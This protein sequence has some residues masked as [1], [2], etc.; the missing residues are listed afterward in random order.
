MK[1]QISGILATGLILTAGV[2]FGAIKEGEFSISPVIGGYTF[3]NKQ[4]TDTSLM[5]GARAGYSLTESFGIEA[6]FDYVDAKS[7]QSLYRYGGELL[8]HFMP[9][10]R[11]VP[12][13][14][15]G[16]AGINLDF[17]DVN[18]RVHGAFDYGLGAKYFLTDS[19]ALRADVRH[20]IY[21]YND[22]TFNNVEYTL[23]AYIPFGGVKPAVKPLPVEEVVMPK[24]A[25]PAPPVIVEEA[26]KVEPLPAPT[27]D[28]NVTPASITKGQ[29]ATLAWKSHNTSVCDI[30]PGIGPVQTQGS[31]R[32]TPSDTTT[33]TLKCSGAGGVTTSVAGINVTAPAPEPVQAAAQPKASAA[34]ERFCSKPAVIEVKFDTNK[35]DIK[36]KFAADLKVLGAFLQEFPKAKGE[37]SGHTDNVGGKAFNIKLSQR[38]ADS[39][40]KYLVDTFKIDAERI[41]AKG[42][43]F[44]KPVADN[45]TKAGKA[46][47][48]RIEAN[49]NCE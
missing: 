20:I 3:D 27:S 21:K 30:Q 2:A 14:A 1:K 11:F 22:T 31:T 32:I 42:Y 40:K 48:R 6:L 12:Y 24:A 43:G 36:P 13:V 9:D 49:F 47:N 37:V 10:N 17:K 33:Y 23:G 8:Y 39:V 7:N 28:L 45:K 5:A 41:A 34:A 29:P 15:A 46:K 4:H 26:K 19:I 16:F 18:N 38:R 44:A 25:A 35:S